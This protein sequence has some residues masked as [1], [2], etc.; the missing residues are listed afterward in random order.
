MLY[1]MGI[2]GSLLVP[3]RVYDVYSLGQVGALRNG[4]KRI[5]ASASEG[6]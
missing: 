4:Y 1:E 3:P 6:I 2:G 5:F